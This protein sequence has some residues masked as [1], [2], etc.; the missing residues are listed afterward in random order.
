ML[1]LSASIPAL[2]SS[3]FLITSF[4]ITGV[5]FVNANPDWCHFNTP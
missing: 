1:I 4:T 2:R 3:A 5:M